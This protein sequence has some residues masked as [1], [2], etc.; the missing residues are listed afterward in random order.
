[1][2][3]NAIHPDAAIF[4]RGVIKQAGGKAARVFKAVTQ[5]DGFADFIYP[6]VLPE[7]PDLPSI[8]L[9]GSSTNI[10][11]DV[12]APTYTAPTF[13]MGI[14]PISLESGTRSNIVV[15]SSWVQADAGAPTAFSITLAGQTGHTGVSPVPFTFNNVQFTDAIQTV[16][17]SVT[18]A[19]GPIKNDEE[20]RPHPTG[21][22]GMGTANRSATFQGFRR[23]FWEAR[24]SKGNAP[25]TS[26]QIRGLTEK[27]SAGAQRVFVIDIPVGTFDIIFAFPVILGSNI[28]VRS[29]IFSGINYSSA[30]TR[31]VVAVEGAEGFNAVNYNVF[32]FSA[33]IGF[34]VVDRYTIT[35]S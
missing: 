20:G 30:F 14:S 10:G 28:D 16:N 2:G 23:A 19:A 12:T 29:Q 24:T 3:Y 8:L 33:D 35:I 26:A 13:T 22:V 25:T 27:S 34:P 32:Y 18:W 9:H 15:N 5:P 11:G 21:A 17:A 31:S 7:T 6:F 4:H 1:M